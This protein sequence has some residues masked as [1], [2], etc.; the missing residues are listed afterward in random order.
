HLDQFSGG[1]SLDSAGNL[2]IADVDNNRI[3]KVDTKGTITT[4]V[5][6]GGEGLSGDGGPATSADLFW[7]A[8]VALDSA[9][10]LYIADG[11]NSRVRMVKGLP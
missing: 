5:G 10:N 7:P 8:G 3:R 4:V 2:Y 6:T 9:G 1:R 11:Q